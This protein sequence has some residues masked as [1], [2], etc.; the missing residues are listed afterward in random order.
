VNISCRRPAYRDVLSNAAIVLAD[1]IG[2]RLAGRILHQNVRENVNGTDMLPYLCGALELAGQSLYLLGG[3]PGVADDVS[4]W[5]QENYPK[6]RIAGTENGYF[7]PEQT[8][9]VVAGIRATHPSVLLVAMGAPRQDEW[10]RAHLKE[11]GAGVVIGVGGLFDFYSGRI[12]RAP[13][14]IRE[15]GLEWFYRFLQEPRRMFRRYLLGNF[16]F[17][18]RIVG[19]RSRQRK[20]V[21]AEVTPQ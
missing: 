2:V 18:A 10:A 11:L 7:D 4:A 13:A 12:S 8:A 17:I 21:S 6:L 9:E 20:S 16:E 3:Q 14:W 1:G 19:E 5:V 15:L